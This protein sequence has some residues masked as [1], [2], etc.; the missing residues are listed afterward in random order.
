MGDRMSIKG[1]NLMTKL[2]HNISVLSLGALIS[3]C[4]LPGGELK[5]TDLPPTNSTLLYQGAFTS[6]ASVTGAAK[7]Y[8]SNGIIYL[9]LESYSSPTATQAVAFISTTTSNDFFHITLK[10]SSGSQLYNTGLASPGIATPFTQVLIRQNSSPSS[11]T[12]ATAY[13]SSVLPPGI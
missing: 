10:A 12:L 6:T 2:S 5:S 3:A 8:L 1:V 9:Y 13:L 11:T 7:I 4:G